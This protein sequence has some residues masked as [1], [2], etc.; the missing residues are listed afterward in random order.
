[1]CCARRAGGASWGILL[2]F[3][4]QLWG[5]H[6]RLSLRSALQGEKALQGCKEGKNWSLLLGVLVTSYFWYIVGSVLLHLVS[7]GAGF[8]FPLLLDAITR[9]LELC[10]AEAVGSCLTHHPAAGLQPAF[11][12]RAQWL[13]ARQGCAPGRDPSGAESSP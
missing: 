1:M 7:T 9:Y 8:A 12:L 6:P 2:G 11:I 13:K 5:V 4:L 3:M 10:G